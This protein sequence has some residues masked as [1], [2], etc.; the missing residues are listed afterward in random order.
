MG[1]DALRLWSKGFVFGV[2]PE[3]C[4]NTCTIKRCTNPR[5]FYLIILII[6]MTYQVCL[7]NAVWAIL[8][9][10]LTIER[11][12]RFTGSCD[13]VSTLL[14]RHTADRKHSTTTKVQYTSTVDVI[15]RSRMAAFVALLALTAL[16]SSYG[17]TVSIE[18][19]NMLAT[20]T[21]TQGRIWERAERATAPGLSPRRGSPHYSCNKL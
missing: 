17:Q 15:E 14:T 16:S 12:R 18:V 8:R 3:L 6:M 1:G 4:R 7:V 21:V 10:E 5:I 19:I 11:K 9:V 20:S 13:T 2:V